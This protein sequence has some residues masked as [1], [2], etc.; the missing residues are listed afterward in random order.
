MRMIQLTGLT[1]GG[2]IQISVDHIVAV[3]E[4]EGQDGCNVMLSTAQV[5]EVQESLEQIDYLIEGN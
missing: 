5:M 4:R 2:E 3:V 1:S